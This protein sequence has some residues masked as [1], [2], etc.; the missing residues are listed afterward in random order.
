[1]SLNQQFGP[2]LLDTTKEE[3]LRA[4]SRKILP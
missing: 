1:M 4:P 3:E 2:E